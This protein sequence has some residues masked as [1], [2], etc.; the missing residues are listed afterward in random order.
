MEDHY[1][2]LCLLDVI[3][4]ILDE[5]RQKIRKFYSDTLGKSTAD[6]MDSYTPEDS[7]LMKIIRK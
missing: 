1:I 5:E 7:A 2:K 4:L 3:N 6:A